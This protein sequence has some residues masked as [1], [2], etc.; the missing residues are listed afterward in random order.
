MGKFDAVADLVWT[1]TVA[2]YISQVG[3]G[4]VPGPPPGDAPDDA[5][6]PRRHAPPPPPRSA[7]RAAKR[8]EEEEDDEEETHHCRPVRDLPGRGGRTPRP[9]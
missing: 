8:E 2:K 9:T 7:G 1:A 5:P 6:A 3:P 4:D